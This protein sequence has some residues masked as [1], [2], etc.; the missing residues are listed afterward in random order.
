ME[1]RRLS[2]FTALT[3]EPPF[4]SICIPQ[5]SRYPHLKLQMDRLAEQSCPDFEVCIS[6]DVS[7]ERQWD[8]MQDYLRKLGLRFSYRVQ[9]KSLRYD[10]N[11][12]S[13]MDL[14]RGRYALLMGNDDRLIDRETLAKL[15]QRLT[16]ASFPEVVITNY[17]DLIDGSEY[18][19]VFEDGSVQSGLEGALRTYRNYSF[20]SGVLIDREA[21]I[22]HR[23]V[24]WDGSEMYQMALATRIVATGGRLF[25]LS[26]IYIEQNIQIPGTQVDRFD[27]KRDPVPWLPK[28]KRLPLGRYAATS[29]DAVAPAVSVEA[30]GAVAWRILRQTLLF[31]YPYWLVKYRGSLGWRY[32]LNIALGM[33]PRYVLEGMPDLASLRWRAR[34][35]Y[36]LATAAGLFCP[37]ALFRKLATRLH[38]FGK[39]GTWRQAS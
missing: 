12:R 33:R 3:D 25:G 19:R 6:D 15:K 8:D 7:P 36:L 20:V 10:A 16:A 22:K 35:A 29:W 11:L 18:R 1:S 9:E 2:F 13:V 34:G 21:A 23:S 14:A 17:R 28:A 38:R 27:T 30:R 39:K 32:A 31:P 26:D 24:V 5:Y 4:F 37:Q